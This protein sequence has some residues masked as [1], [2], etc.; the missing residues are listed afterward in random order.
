MLSQIK[1]DKLSAEFMDVYHRDV[2]N[3]QNKKERK[4]RR[5]RNILIKNTPGRRHCTRCG[6]RDFLKEYES[7]KLCKRCFNTLSTT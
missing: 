6:V 2:L 5:K 3:K 7:H 1:S 4:Q